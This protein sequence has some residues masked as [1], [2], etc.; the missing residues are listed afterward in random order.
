MRESHWLTDIRTAALITFVISVTSLLPALWAPVTGIIAVESEHPEF[1][2]WATPMMLLTLLLTVTLPVFYFALFRNEEPI[3]IPRRLRPYALVGILGL[4]I[5]VVSTLP[6]FVRFF[7]GYWSLSTRLFGGGTPSGWE[8][9]K[10]VL[11][12]VSDITSTFYLLSCSRKR[13]T[14][15]DQQSKSHDSCESRPWRRPLVLGCKWRSTSSESSRFRLLTEV[16]WNMLNTPES[17]L[18]PFQILRVRYCLRCYRALAS[19]PHPMSSGEVWR[20]AQVAI[21][22]SQSL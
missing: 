22:R 17:G 3:R 9:T 20:P 19:S 1:K 21:C 12:E 7:S 16:S 14:N 15:H 10:L 18:R 2:V 6:E 13:M 8:A 4:G 11:A 5:F